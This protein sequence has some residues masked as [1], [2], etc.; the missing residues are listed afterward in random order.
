MEFNAR[1]RS[2]RREG[3]AYLHGG[4]G[5]YTITVADEDNLAAQLD[6]DCHVASTGCSLTSTN[7][8]THRELL[9]HPVFLQVSRLSPGFPIQGARTAAEREGLL[10][11]L[12][13]EDEDDEEPVS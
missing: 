8:P 1:I 6:R 10:A 11:A 4:G 12:A 9:E 13:A 2:I 5:D 7:S 3:Q